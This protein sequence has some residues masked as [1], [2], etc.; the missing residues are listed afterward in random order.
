MCIR[1]REYIIDKCKKRIPL[2]QQL[3]QN[4]YGYQYKAR[5]IMFTGYIYSLLMYSSSIYYHRL[6][7]KTYR[8]LVDR[9]QRACNIVIC[10]GYND[11]TGESA[12]ILAAEEPL[13][14]RIIER[15]VAWLLRTWKR[16][17]Y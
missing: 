10:R 15:S 1:D 5:Q 17:L 8:T 14:L 11:I 9:L 13:A 2:L 4:T 16:V 7:L 6:K 12:S 3:C